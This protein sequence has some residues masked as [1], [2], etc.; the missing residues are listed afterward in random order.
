MQIATTYNHQLKDTITNI[1]GVNIDIPV[2]DFI[3][4]RITKLIS[5]NE[6]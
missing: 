1:A 5:A 4:G 3:P 2:N 6:Y